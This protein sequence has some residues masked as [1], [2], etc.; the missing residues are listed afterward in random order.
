MKNIIEHSIMAL[1]VLVGM[2]ATAQVADTVII[3]DETINASSDPALLNVR[4]GQ[5]ITIKPNTWIQSGTVFTAIVTADA[6]IPHILNTDENYVFTRAF[7]SPITETMLLDPTIGIKNNSDVIENITYFDGLGRDKQQVDIKASPDKKD[8]VTHID[9]DDYGRQDK[10]Y[11]PFERQA[12]D[13]GSYTTVDITDNIN[14]YYQTKYQEDFTGVTTANINAYSESIF[15]ASPL[16][17][18]LEQGAPG[19]DWKADDQVD[20]DHTIKFDWTTNEADEVVYFKVNFHLDNTEVP[21]LVKDAYYDPNELMVTITKDEN[22]QPGQTYPEDHTT[23]EYTDK[24]GRVAL[25]RTFD[26][27]VSHDTYYVYDDFGNLT[28]VIPP[29]VDITDGVSPEE[30]SELCYQYKY[31]RR[32]RLVEKKIPGKGWEYIIYNKLDQPILTQDAVQ[33]PKREWLCTKYDA[34]GRVV[35]TGLEKFPWDTT[36]AGLQNNLDNDT[37]PEYEDRTDGFIDVNGTKLYYSNNT[38]P[39]GGDILT[40]NYY[41][42]YDFDWDYGGGFI[43]HPDLNNAYD[44]PHATSLKGLATGS[45]VRILGTDKWIVSY[46]LYDKKG[47]PIYV[48]SFNEYLGTVDIVSSKLDFAG[49]VEET[50]TIHRKTGQ[51]EIRTIDTFTYDHMGRLLDQ[52]QTINNQAEEH[53]IANTYDEL[54]QLES[55]EV[56]GGLQDVDYTYNVRGWLNKINNDNK[57]DNDLFDFSIAYNDI[58]DV[59]KKLYNG[60]ISQTSW[61]TASVNN[62]SNPESSQYIYSYDALNR[63]KTAIDNTGNYDLSNVTYDKNGNI[64]NLE[65]KGNL[66]TAVTSF[67]VMDNLTYT[68]NE[69]G[70]GNQL[71]KVVDAANDLQGFKDSLTNENDYLYDDNGNMTKDGNKNITAITYNHLNLPTRVVFQSFG[72]EP[73]KYIAYIYDATG[74]KLEKQVQEAVIL[75]NSGV[76]PTYGTNTIITEYAGNYIYKGN[77]T[78][79]GG[80]SSFRASNSGII[81]SLEFMNHPE[82]YVEPNGT[83]GF[84]YIYQYKDHLGNIRLSYS[85][86]NKDGDIDII[87][88]SAENEIIEEKNYYPFGIEH[89][90]YNNVISGVPHNYKYNGKEHQQ[91]LGLDWYD[92]GWRNYDASVGR[93]MNIDPHSENY[94]S[95]SPYNSF[96][97]NPISFVDPDGRDLLFWQQNDDGEWEQVQFDQLSKEVQESLTA[98]AK[99]DEGF[100]FL[101]NFANEGDKIGDVEFGET[102]QYA[103]H[104]LSF[105]EFNYYGGASGSSKAKQKNGDDK[106]TFEW[107]LNS[108]YR[109]DQKSDGIDP[110]ASNAIT[111]G[112]EAFIHYSQYIDELIEAFDSGDMDRVNE[113][114][115]ERKAIARNGGGRS[116]HNDFLDSKSEFKQMRTYLTQLKKVLNPSSVNKALKAHNK[117][118][119]RRRN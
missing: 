94:S 16:N 115:K 109:G 24:L 100:S 67:G 63:I 19:K 50:T 59:T 18:V 101:S 91:E 117:N 36:R 103:K 51:A 107:T 86:K 26:Q 68:Y 108:A 58:T 70:I 85:D 55:K 80:S 4:A 105:G 72:T 98:F 8:I 5:S 41:D 64:L 29:K 66:N 40:I 92:F 45:K 96:A 11:L 54:G 99:T 56:G 9:Y 82:G 113:I 2:T 88:G 104:E 27:G 78:G 75:D 87:S 10:Q 65:R 95:L 57:N 12:G 81:T 49:K 89:K 23:K 35:F 77:Q 71:L 31:D 62:T 33:R 116:E 15:E 37:I 34:F 118:L 1:L 6:Y 25:K 84:D 83:N 38:F 42:N 13:V 20:T 111:N 106:L 119:E 93:W 30:L 112:H 76:V 61:S 110:T 14:I 102:G 47:R 52:K 73:D 21:I 79:G 97:N 44:Q 17:R 60:N 114:F 43:Y 46:T 74:I 7:Q 28:Y 69:N 90:G 53:L 48:A 39:G 22:W 3:E 32:N